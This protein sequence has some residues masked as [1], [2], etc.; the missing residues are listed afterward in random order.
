VERRDRRAIWDA[1]I[2]REVYGTSGPRILLWF[3]LLNSPDGTQPMGSEVTLATV[4]RFEVRA[5]GA[6]EQ[7]PGCPTESHAG[8][9]AERLEHLCRGECYNPSDSRTR[10]AAIEVVRIRPQITPDEQ[11]GDLIEDPWR[12]FDCPPDPNGC[13]VTFEDPD[14]V[15]GGRDMVYYVRALQAATPAINGANYRTEYDADGN[16][17]RT[18]PCYGG[19]RTPFEDDCLAPV[20]E[21]AWSSPIFVDQP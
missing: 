1:L 19:Y 7:R 10:I 2:R 12:R 4:P 5:V 6:L 16:A 15:P 8:L 14:Y 3:D 20:Q 17:V 9:P 18:R 11:V 13:V 21:R